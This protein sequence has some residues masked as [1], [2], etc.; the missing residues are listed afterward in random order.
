MFSTK[1]PW[2]TPHQATSPER[3]YDAFGEPAGEFCQYCQRFVAEPCSTHGE[4]TL[5]CTPIYTLGGNHAP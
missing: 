5:P 4:I 2:E 1:P 3:P